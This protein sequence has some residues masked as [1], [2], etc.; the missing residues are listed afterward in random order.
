MTIVMLAYTAFH[1]DNFTSY[2]GSFAPYGWAAPLTAIATSGIALAY[3]GF[4]SIINLAGEVKNP[5]RNVPIALLA[6]IL[7]AM[8]LYVLLQ[9]TFIGAVDPKQLV[10][11][12]HQ[13]NFSSPFAELAIA[14]NLHVLLISI[15]IDAF[16]SPSGVG[17]TYLA[18]TGRMLYG[19]S[20]NGYMPK[21]MAE[22]P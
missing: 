16:I 12:W 11:G 4:Q 18:T 14:L 5:N 21:F 13:L 17:V 6:S 10:N 9:V 1:P 3:R 7:I 22:Y 20:Q 8:L 19:M 2:G 15:Y